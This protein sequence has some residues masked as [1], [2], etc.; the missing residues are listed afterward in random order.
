MGVLESGP[1]GLLCIQCLAF[2]AGTSSLLI[3]AESKVIKKY[4]MKVDSKMS[5]D[6]QSDI[7]ETGFCFHAK[8][9]DIFN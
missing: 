7:K 4:N 1:S 6:L 3:C 2:R 9:I 8:E 5:K